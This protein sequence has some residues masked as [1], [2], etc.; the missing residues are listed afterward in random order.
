MRLAIVSG[1]ADEANLLLFETL[2]DVAESA[3]FFGTTRCAVF[4]IEVN[5]KRGVLPGVEALRSTLV[6]ER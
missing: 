6:I 4:R 3:R 5:E 2:P 1:H